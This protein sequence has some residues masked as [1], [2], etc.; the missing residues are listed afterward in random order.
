MN[1]NYTF[2]A[3]LVTF[4]GCAGAA[5]NSAPADAPPAVPAPVTV[6]AT[7][8]EPEVSLEQRWAAPF[9]VETRG[10]IAPREARVVVVLDPAQPT[11]AKPAVRVARAAADSAHTARAGGGTVAAAESAP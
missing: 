9:A 1:R 11:A 7:V 3:L 8:A 4:T 10:R 2:V 5:Q 6:A